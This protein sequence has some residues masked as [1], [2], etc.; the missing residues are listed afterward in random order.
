MEFFR[1]SAPQQSPPP[2]R[3]P[4]RCGTPTLLCDDFSTVKVVVT[5]YVI[6]HLR[7][8]S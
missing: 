3:V 2:R 6:V 7:A 8:Y 1:N 5:R 4:E